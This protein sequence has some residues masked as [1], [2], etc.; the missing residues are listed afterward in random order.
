[1]ARAA[2]ELNEQV[3]TQTILS[4]PPPRDALDS[5][6]L[7]TQPASRW[8]RTNSAQR[9]ISG[10]GGDAAHYGRGVD[11]AMASN[12]GGSILRRCHW[13]GDEAEIVP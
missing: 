10:G 2:A 1:M 12:L 3:R 7:L 8:S 9:C 11:V 13:R 5:L 4:S 6:M